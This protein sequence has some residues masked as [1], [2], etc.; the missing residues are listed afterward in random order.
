MP[1]RGHVRQTNP[2]GQEHVT[3]PDEL[4]AEICT[5]RAARSR[6]CASISTFSQC[7]LLCLSIREAD[8]PLPTTSRHSN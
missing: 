7:P 3:G 5:Y 2:D 8:R 4:V 6:C 1:R